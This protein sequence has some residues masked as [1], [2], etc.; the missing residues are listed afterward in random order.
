M[1]K[2]IIFDSQILNSVQLCAYKTELTFGKNLQPI[3]KAEPMEEGDLLHKMFEFYNSKLKENPAIVYEDSWENLV[4]E[5]TELGGRYSVEL[6]LN[7][8]E[9]DSVIYQ[10][11][12][13]TKFTRMDGVKVLEVEKPFIIEL[14]QD[15]QLGI[16]YTGKID[17]Y[18]ETPNFG[19]V[20]RDYKKAAQN[21]RPSSLSNQFTGYAFATWPKDA[22]IHY[23]IVDKVGFQK[24]LPPE[25]RFRS[26]PLA[27]TMDMI[28]DWKE[29]SIWWGKQY[30]YFLE[31]G[32]WPKNRTSCDKYGGCIFEDICA[33]ATEEAR[34]HKLNTEFIVGEKWDPTKV[35]RKKEV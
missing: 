3:Q 20:P 18:T 22:N 33:S 24:T 34:L 4:K 1:R 13:Y 28:D 2:N 26:Y 30:A 9:V 29:N 32:T 6:S 21:R 10:F 17:R 5:A 14:Y 23:V 11:T 7:A 12:E 25:E 31:T 35:L 15:D 8:A 16:Y 27:Y 19:L